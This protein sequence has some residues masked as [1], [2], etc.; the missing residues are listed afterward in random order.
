MLL[1]R[2]VFSGLALCMV[3]CA[4]A[5]NGQ[6]AKDALTAL[7]NSIGT[8]QFVLRNFSGEDKVQATWTG[9]Q[10]DLAAAQW[11][12]MGVL[13]LQSIKLSGKKL[14]LRCIR[15]VLVK[16][17]QGQLSLYREPTEVQIDVDLR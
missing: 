11:Q 3:V 2:K 5:M 6:A 15:R 13:Q 4:Q 14:T 12:T 1:M 9:T 7:Q 17:S 8:S 16:D 10:A